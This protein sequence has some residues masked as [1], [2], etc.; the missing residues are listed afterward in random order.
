MTYFKVYSLLNVSSTVHFSRFFCIGITI[1]F[2]SSFLNAATAEQL[3]AIKS[4]A[5]AHVRSLVTQPENGV[6]SIEA[7][8][9]DSRIRTSDCPV[10]L[11]TSLPGNKRVSDHSSILVQC[12]PDKWRVYVPVR[13]KLMVPLI[14]AVKPLSRGTVLSSSDLTSTL[15]NT[16]TY[17]KGGFTDKDKI[18]GPRVKRS[19]RMG[20]PIEKGDICLVCRN[21]K[22]IIKAVK[23][24]LSI[25]T[26]GTALNDG[27]LGEQVKV[28]NDKSKR[29]IE[30]IV[31]NVG[32][33]SVRF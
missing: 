9:L 12:L 17:R 19:V 3:V 28:K 21:D 14:T 31:T 8:Y 2:F 33:I 32:E 15:V 23:G 30:G 6:L 27:S 24:G 11:E 4:A 26:K 20:E 1:F 10:A 29:I 5:T 16:N 25:V 22:V 13:T 7:G 18:I